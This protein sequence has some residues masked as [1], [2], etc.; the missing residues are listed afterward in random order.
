MDRRPDWG[1]GRDDAFGLPKFVLTQAKDDGTLATTDFPALWKLGERKGTLYH[2]GGEA[3][4]LSMVIATSALG[5]GAL[6]GPGF[7]RQNEWTATFI[8]NLTPP[9]F[10]GQ[11]DAAKAAEGQAL[12][13]QHC[14]SCHA[15]ARTGTSIP[16]AEIGTDPEHVKTWQDEDARRMKKVGAIL[17]VSEPPMIAAKG[18]VAKPLV[19]V[20]LLGPYLHNG[21]VPTLADLLTAP[22][23]RPKVFWRGYDLVD[24]QNIGFVSSGHEAEKHGFRYDTRLRGN[25]NGGHAWGTALPADQKLALIEYLKGL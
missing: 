19:G 2:A 4:E 15:G 17:G 22:A 23:Q 16:L 25:T 7:D 8:E 3:A 6:P 18:Y 21:S 9:P 13:A 10:P 20:W 11:T 14:A 1:P 5:T 24:Q 12:F